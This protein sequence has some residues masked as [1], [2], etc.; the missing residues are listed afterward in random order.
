MRATWP[1]NVIRRAGVIAA[2]AAVVAVVALTAS[3]CGSPTATRTAG[4][5]GGTTN[6]LQNQTPDQVMNDAIAALRSATSVQLARTPPRS[7]GGPFKLAAVQVQGDAVI[8]IFAGQGRALF[9]TAFVG[10]NAYIRLSREALKHASVPSL[11]KHLAAGRWVRMRRVPALPGNPGKTALASWAAWLAH[12][13]P[14]APAVRPAMLNGRKVVVITG[15]KNGAKLYVANTGRP[16]PLLA[17][18]LDGHRLEWTDYGA[19]FDIPTP[20][21]T[22]PGGPG[23]TG[24]P[25]T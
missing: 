14:L 11:F 15:P 5:G 22:A 12:H 10:K 25:L 4:A 1:V 2:A 16:Y 13:G 20:A 24:P 9:E 18:F 7:L 8:N 19:H 6:G 3:G 17:T 21:N 23:Y